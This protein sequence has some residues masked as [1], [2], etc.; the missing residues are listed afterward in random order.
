MVERAATH[1]ETGGYHT[2][3]L[4]ADT[5]LDAVARDFE[6]RRW[7]REGNEYV[8]RLAPPPSARIDDS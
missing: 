8:K 1:A 7:F 3:H 2:L 4:A 5:S 6:D